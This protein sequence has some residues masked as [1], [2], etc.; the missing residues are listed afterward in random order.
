[1]AAPKRPRSGS[2]KKGQGLAAG[3]ARKA[4]ARTGGVI[5]PRVPKVTNKV[6]SLGRNSNWLGRK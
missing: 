3:G 2:N 5:S 6:V 4:K 1:M